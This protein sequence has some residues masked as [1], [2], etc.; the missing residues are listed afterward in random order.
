MD[1]QNGTDKVTGDSSHEDPWL[2]DEI[3]LCIAEQYEYPSDI[4]PMALC[5]RRLYSALVELLYQKDTELEGS[6]LESSAAQ[7]LRWDRQRRKGN[8]LGNSSLVF[9]IRTADTAVARYALKAASKCDPQVL[10][11]GFRCGQDLLPP[12]LRSFGKCSPMSLAATLG[13]L[14]IFKLLVEAG[15][16]IKEDS[17]EPDGWQSYAIRYDAMEDAVRAGQRMIVE[18]LLDE[19]DTN[20]PGMLHVAVAAGHLDLATM[21]LDRFPGLVNERRNYRT[22]LH[23]AVD[24]GEQRATNRL[25][26]ERYNP[27]VIPILDLLLSRGADIEA[28]SW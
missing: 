28:N 15:C 26:A 20:S 19:H 8:T 5:N 4:L 6:L 9:A 24:N 16:S 3:I 23:D 11:E 12:A 18:Y 22:P 25:Q 21:F 7:M 2:P 14:E 10:A 13:N 17:I 1:S 27:P